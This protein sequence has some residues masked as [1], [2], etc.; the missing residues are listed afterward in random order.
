MIRIRRRRMNV[1]HL[2]QD[3]HR[4]QQ[5]TGNRNSAHIRKS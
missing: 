4:Q 3:Q 1:T 5:H 2:H